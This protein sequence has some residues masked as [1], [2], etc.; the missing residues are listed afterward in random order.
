MESRNLKQRGRHGLSDTDTLPFTNDDVSHEHKHGAKYGEAHAA[1]LHGAAPP[2]IY[3]AYPAAAASERRDGGRGSGRSGGI[4]V[5][6]GG[7]DPTDFSA[8]SFNAGVAG[9][10]RS[11]DLVITLVLTVLSLATRLYR[12][13]RRAN[14][15][16]DEAHHG[17][18]GAY[19]INGTFYHDVHPPL[20]K[21]LV[22]LAEAIAGHNGTFTFGSGKHYPDYVNYVSMRI[23][24]ALYGV[25]LVPL[26]YLTCLQLRLSRP[27]AAL[28]ASFILFDNAICVMSRFVLLDQPLLFFTAMSLW[29][30]TG[31]QNISSRGQSFTNKWWMWLFVTGFS[32]GC[33]ISTKW[34][35]LFCVILVGIAT[36]EDLFRKYCALMPWDEYG[37]HWFARMNTLVLLPLIIYTLCFWVHFKLLYRVGSGDHKLSSNFQARQI[38]HRLNIQPYDVTYGSFV[39][40]RSLFNGPGLLHSHY[41]QYPR[42]SKQQQVTCF[43]HR[44]T[45]NVWQLHKAHGIDANYTLDRIEFV[46]HGDIVQLVHNT[47]GATLRASKQ[48]LAPL[49]TSHFEVAAENMTASSASGASNWQV[50]VVKQSYSKRGDKQLHAMTTSFRL[51]HVDLGCLLRVGSRRLPSWG[52]SQSEVT[53][54]PDS[55]HKKDIKSWDVLWYV[56]HNANE[57]MAK[58]D[59][60]KYVSS[61][62]LVNMIQLNIE[63]GK[64]NNALWPDVNKYSSLESSPWS[65]LFLTY[66]MR[67]VGWGD[68]SIKYYEIGNPLLWWASA[69]V[70]IVYPLRMLYWIG[71][72]RRQCNDWRPGELLEFWDNSK[73]LWGG[74]ALQYLPFFLMGRVTYI[75]H[76]LP[77]LYFGLLL[78]AFELD[79]FFRHWR[80]GRFLHMAAWSIGLVVAV[81]FLY[82]SPFTYG[83]NRPAKELA[84]RKWLSSWNIYEDFYAM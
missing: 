47:T 28:A 70:C 11:R 15:T 43:P 27:M 7:E 74:W 71:R 62:F 73:F 84:G 51:R 31:F 2:N 19:Y 68:K 45:N 65:W 49:T 33:T 50:E 23:Q 61:N 35:G 3:T 5:S 72:Q 14:V 79:F 32:L 60:S 59:L 69:I 63:M 83:W 41:H 66:P 57:R 30:A 26:A 21:M 16:W 4:V 77:A 18:F 81:V 6:N 12:I 53:C 80:R 78:L 20:A 44:D 10:L 8:A 1:G 52:W 76:Y 17:K 54:L 38:G 55:T 40:I 75:H 29:G 46:H 82:F 13:G 36:I 9:I 67:M 48:F 37:A 25:A 22:G 34:A 24:L 64:T 39:E 42:M 58:D 56:E